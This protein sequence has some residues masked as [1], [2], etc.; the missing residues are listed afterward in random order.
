MFILLT[1]ANFPDI[2]L[3]AFAHSYWYCW[4]FIIFLLLGLYFMINML[5]AHVYT[6]FKLRVTKE[7][8]EYHDKFK[9]CLECYINRFDSTI[10]WNDEMDDKK[11]G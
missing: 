1:T 3:P 10:D 9:D 8:L 6:R 5:L 7:S 4:Y 11:G 2:M